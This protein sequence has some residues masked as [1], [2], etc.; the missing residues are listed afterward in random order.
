MTVTVFLELN[1]QKKKIVTTKS[2]MSVV[3]IPL[4]IFHTLSD[5]AK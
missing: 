2:K 5:T 3:S 1:T 4:K